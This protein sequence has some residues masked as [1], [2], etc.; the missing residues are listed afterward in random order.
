MLRVPPRRARR[1]EPQPFARPVFLHRP[2]R[3]SYQFTP[4]IGTDV[5][6]H[7]VRA[8]GAPRAFIRADARIVGLRRQVAIAQFAIGTKFERRH[9]VLLSSLYSA[10]PPACGM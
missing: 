10:P 9:G 4:A 1:V 7:I 3:A 6:Q 8:V 5:E 2:D